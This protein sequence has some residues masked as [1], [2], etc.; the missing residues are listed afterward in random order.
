ML[1]NL[2]NNAIKFTP[3]EGSILI[4]ARTTE[5]NTRI[6]IADTGPGIEPERLPMITNPFTRGE[7]NPL[8]S[9]KGWG[10]GLAIAKALV[11]LHKGQME[12]ASTVGKGTSITISIPRRDIEP[13][14]PFDR[15]PLARS[16]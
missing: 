16:R 7:R 8:D 5:A 10:L 15:E 2:V 6:T 11:D 1:I 12:I 4:K 3:P 14:L 9:E 13:A